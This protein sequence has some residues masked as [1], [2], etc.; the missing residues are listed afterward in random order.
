MDNFREILTTILSISNEKKK[1][2]IIRIVNLYNPFPA[3]IA[4][5]HWI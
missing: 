4:I 5:D 3:F 2:A 1:P